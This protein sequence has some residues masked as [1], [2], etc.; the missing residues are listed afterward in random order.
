MAPIPIARFEFLRLETLH[1]NRCRRVPSAYRRRPQRRAAGTERLAMRPVEEPDGANR[2]R[3]IR[4][5]GINLVRRGDRVHRRCG[6]STGFPEP[7]LKET[8]LI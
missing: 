1:E 5:H 4:I 7:I 6:D 2:R 3:P 8:W